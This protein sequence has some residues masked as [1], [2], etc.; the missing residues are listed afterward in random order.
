VRIDRGTA[1]LADSIQTLI[2]RSTASLRGAG[3]S[4]RGIAVASL[5]DGSLIW[6]VPDARVSPLGTIAA[7]LAA[8]AALE[9]AAP[10]GCP[11]ATL[12]NLGRRLSSIGAPSSPFAVP[13]GALLVGMVDHGA[14][15]SAL[16]SCGDPAAALAAD[17]A[18]WAPFGGIVLH[19][20]DFRFGFFATPES[21]TTAEAK[22]S[23]LTVPGLPTT[24]IDSL[25]AS[26]LGFYD[27]LDQELEQRQPGLATRFDLCRALGSEAPAVL[28]AFANAWTQLLMA[29]P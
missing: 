29:Q 11:T 18:C 12:F 6:S 3:L 1:N 19:R 21:G 14:R 4:P 20:A 27:P 10:T 7:A 15:P 13:P 28:G 25:E 8:R 2:Q 5:Y 22:A 9:N 16:S 24:I 23:C 26:D 17:V